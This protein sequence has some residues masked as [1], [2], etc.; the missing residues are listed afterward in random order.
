M[1]VVGLISGT[2]FDGIDVAAA[3]LRLDGD[4]V[5][6]GPLGADT[7]AY[8]PDV[9]DALVAAMP[10]RAVTA[11]HLCRLDTRV[12]QAFADAAARAVATLAGGE[13]DLVASHGQTLYHW[14]EGRR[15]LGT[16]QAGQSA[17]IAERTGLPVVADLR[18]RDV[19]AGGHGAPLASTLDVL[20]LGEDSP[21][22]R[23][24]LNLGG[25]ANITVTGGGR[26]AI[27]Y[28]TG[29]ANALVDVAVESATEGAAGYDEDGRMAAEGTVDDALLDRLLDDPYYGLDPPKS[30]G[31]EHFHLP[32]LEQ[33]LAGRAVDEDVVATVTALTAE[34]VARECRR[35]GVTEVLASGGGTA[36]P[37]LM[38]M[39]AER[40]GD[41]VGL[42]RID[43]LGL[44]S[45]S[46]EAYLMTL[47]GFLTAHG[48]PGTFPTC[49]G[50][51]HAS[52]LGSVVPGAN[53]FPEVGTPPARP[54]R[55][56]VE[57]RQ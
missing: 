49:T 34:T 22:P 21:E 57:E 8:P 41:R 43:T 6:L 7:A 25:I 32:Y 12:G 11:E 5:V 2:S 40:L 20:L 16:L 38:G 55:L 28:D 10:P 17:W 18:V 31:R 37:V 23:A 45:D 9:R 14:V 27:A 53:G 13:A 29:P 54:R 44:P 4:T 19:A 51:G 42:G 50:A 46:K 35:L 52:V 1:R 47:L 33:R 26:E 3:D 36:N 48:L 24:A 30:T 39:L 15:A 56:R